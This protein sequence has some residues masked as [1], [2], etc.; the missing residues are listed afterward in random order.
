[1][2][3][4]MAQCGGHGSL[5]ERPST[6]IGFEPFERIPVDEELLQGHGLDRRRTFGTGR[7]P[8]ELSHGGYR[9]YIDVNE[10]AENSASSRLSADWTSDS[11][12]DQ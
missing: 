5:A 9:A 3:R 7:A 8:N 1:M 10:P 4:A 6:L 2:P 11:Y 12:G